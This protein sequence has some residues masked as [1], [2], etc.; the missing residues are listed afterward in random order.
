MGES[1]LAIIGT[2]RNGSTLLMRLLDSSPGIW[3]YPVE[4]RYLSD[5]SYLKTPFT[6]TS[7]STNIRGALFADAAAKSRRYA[8]DFLIWAERRFSEFQ[9][10]YVEGMAEPIHS[11]GD[12]MTRL[13][14]QAGE[15]LA[16]N[17]IAF[18][19]LIQAT[20]DHRSHEITP[21]LAYKSIEVKRIGE[22]ARLFPAIRFIHIFRHPNSN[23]SSLKR[24]DMIAKQKP[25]WFQGGDILHELLERRWIP[26]ASYVLD[27]VRTDPNRHLMVRYEDLCDRPVEAVRMICEW[28]N[29][30]PPVDPGLLT[31]LGGR[32]MKELPRNPSK[33]GVKTP[34]RVIPNMSKEFRYEEVLSK[35][36][37]DWIAFRTKQFANEMGYLDLARHAKALSKYSLLA[38]W[39]PLDQ[40]ERMNVDS[41]LQL[42]RFVAMRRLYIFSKLLLS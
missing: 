21:L 35:R 30:D 39:M 15:S 29:V 8:E 22:Y 7:L 24:T 31:V 26:H 6:R 2:G 34:E 19:E 36:E 14:D 11:E 13:A 33:A 28:L 27:S 41:W 25:F 9:A 17:F 16:A 3:V 38:E 5:F 40:W 1:L 37:V 32:R 42:A 23:Y 12:L 18:L 10:I 20:F 4:L